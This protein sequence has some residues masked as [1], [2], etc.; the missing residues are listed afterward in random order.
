M[1]SNH[2]DYFIPLIWADCVK[3]QRE[4]LFHSLSTGFQT[5]IIADKGMLDNSAEIPFSWRSLQFS[6]WKA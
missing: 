2:F 3:D 1:C 4:R 6:M 5:Q